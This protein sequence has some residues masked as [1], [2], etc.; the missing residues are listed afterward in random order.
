VN[1][2]DKFNLASTFVVVEP[3]HAAIPVTV[4]PTIYEELDRRFDRFKGH[5]L[6]SSFSFD[7]DWSSWE[8][9]PAG[10]EI[11]CLLSGEATVVFDRNGVEK[12]VSM[13]EPGTFVIV[14]RGT[15][16]T[17]RTSVPTTMLFVTP[18]EGT[19]NRST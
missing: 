5:L 2:T 18:G 19:Q 4:T 17:A 3:C 7:S 16:H 13:R 8:I 15:W 1:P 9:H 12:A 6:V 11:V 14:P 10:D